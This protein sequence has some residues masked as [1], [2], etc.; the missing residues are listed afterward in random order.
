MRATLD[1]HRSYLAFCFGVTSW[2]ELLGSYQTH[3]LI[4][5]VVCLKPWHSGVHSPVLRLAAGGTVTN[6]QP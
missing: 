4:H 6:P 2:K 1:L 5:Q 3:Y